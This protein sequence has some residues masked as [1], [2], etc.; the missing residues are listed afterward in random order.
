MR[1]VLVS[2]SMVPALLFVTATTLYAQAD[3]ITALRQRVAT[4][5]NVVTVNA[6]EVRLAVLAMAD[7]RVENGVIHSRLQNKL[8]ELDTDQL[9][10]RGDGLRVVK[11]EATGDKQNDYLRITV[12]NA[13]GNTVHL[14]F[15]VSKG[16]L[17]G[18][19]EPSLERLISPVLLLPVLAEAGPSEQAT[20][21][22]QAAPPAAPSTP[23]VPVRMPAAA[24]I[25]DPSLNQTFVATEPPPTTK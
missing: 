6:P 22:E 15:G 7:L 13:A 5:A 17:A 9:A 25:S 3:G 16:T 24:V 11:V 12:A 14:A 21:N 2:C 4:P 19:D 18:M 10:H 20:P 1:P 23:N 8:L